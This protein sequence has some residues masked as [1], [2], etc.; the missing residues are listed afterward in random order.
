MDSQAELTSWSVDGKQI[1]VEDS[2]H[3]IHSYQPDRIVRE[4]LQL[5]ENGNSGSE[6]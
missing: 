4:L 5:I 2:M 6:D 1:I 3:Y